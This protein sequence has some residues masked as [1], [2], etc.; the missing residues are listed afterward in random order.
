LVGRASLHDLHD[1]NIVKTPTKS[2]RR[3]LR[4]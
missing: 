3:L 1:K 4:K 2:W